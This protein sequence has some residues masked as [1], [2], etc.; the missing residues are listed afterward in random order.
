MTSFCSSSAGNIFDS[1]NCETNLILIAIKRNKMNEM[2]ELFM[3]IKLELLSV[4]YF[5][6]LWNYLFDYQVRFERRNVNWH[7]NKLNFKNNQNSFEAVII[8]S[9]KPQFFSRKS[10]PGLQMLSSWRVQHEI[11]KYLREL[12]AF[13]SKY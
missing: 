3:K 12:H 5:K 7:R 9:K 10:D 2:S 11:V 13:E 6:V 8:N 1:K 4:S